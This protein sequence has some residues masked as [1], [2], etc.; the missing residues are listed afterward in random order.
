MQDLA[1]LRAMQVLSV[2]KIAQPEWIEPAS[3]VTNEVWLTPHHVIRIN[4]KATGRL[5]REAYL[6]ECLPMTTGYPGIVA[7]GERGG[8]WLVMHRRPGAPLAHS[9]PTMGNQ[10]RKRATFQI[11]RCLREIHET[12]APDDLSPLAG[13]QMI[14]SGALF[15]TQPIHDAIEHATRL[16]HMPLGLLRDLSV[17]VSELTPAL[18]TFASKTLIHG[19]LTFE[20]VLWDG[21][22]VTAM[23]DFE[24]ARVAPPDLDLD[25]LLRMCA[26][27]HL[28]VAA[29]YE[30]TTRAQDY[31]SVPL[32]MGETYPELFDVPRLTER[33]ELYS[34]AFDL[35]E[36]LSFPPR[37]DLK[38]LPDLHPL[39]RMR[40]TLNGLGHF[41]RW[42]TPSWS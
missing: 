7:A 24:W 27:P 26:L 29:D 32:W 6:A 11:A 17:R 23:I 28:H 9:W 36:L 35:N 4:R 15:P 33:L 16:E 25:V 34:L 30:S 18:G 1:R 5:R 38:Q 14:T 22:N 10:D 2:A 20:N 37:S 3:S 8:D 42:L 41:T 13:P 39:N 19:D 12:H 40:Q 21:K 31:D